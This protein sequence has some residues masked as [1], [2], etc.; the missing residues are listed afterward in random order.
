M[1]NKATHTVSLKIHFCDWGLV[2]AIYELH[3]LK[4]NKKG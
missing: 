4:Q 2:A 1:F 3:V